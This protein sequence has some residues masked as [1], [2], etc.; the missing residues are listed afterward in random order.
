[1]EGGYPIDTENGKILYGRRDE[2]MAHL[3][4]LKDEG[5]DI[6]NLTLKKPENTE[7]MRRFYFLTIEWIVTQNYYPDEYARPDVEALHTRLKQI[8]IP[9][10]IHQIR[11]K[12]TRETVTSIPSTTKLG[13]RNYKIY[14]QSVIDWATGQGYLLPDSTEFNQR[15]KAVGYEA[16]K[17]E[18]MDSLARQLK[19][20]MD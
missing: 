20:K 12:D 14:L 1:M 8:F 18:S 7:Q 15:V 4:R 3:K 5:V 16:A 13:Q 17:V 19:A 9:R 10:K 6:A 2:F 11:M